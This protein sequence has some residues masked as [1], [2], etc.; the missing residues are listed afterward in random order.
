[1]KVGFIG[2]GTMGGSMC[3][4]NSGHEI[5]VHDRDAAAVQRCVDVGVSSMAEAV[6]ESDVVFTSTRRR[7]TRSG[8]RA[9]RCESS[10][11]RRGAGFS[12]TLAPTW[13]NAA[14]AV[15]RRWSLRDPGASRRTPGSSREPST[16]DPP[17]HRLMLGGALHW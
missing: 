7:G 12:V 2:A 17:E 4:K 11:R 9:G 14:S 8:G 6:G 3:R 13:G 5:L 16:D 10:P 15:E 1:M